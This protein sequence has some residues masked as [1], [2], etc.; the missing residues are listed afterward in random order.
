MENNLMK[1]LSLE[2]FGQPLT[3][4]QIEIPQLAH[5]EVLIQVEATPINPSDLLFMAGHYSNSGFKPPCVP[6][7][8]GSGLVV[9]SGG[10]EEADSLLNKR[11]AFIFCKG[12]Y[13]QYTVT[14]S[15]NCLLINDDVTYNQAA[16]SFVNPLTV[17]GMLEVVKEARV[18]TVVHSAAASA[19]GRMMVRYFKNN[20]VEV[21]NIVRRQEQVDI[22]KKEGAT[23]ILNQNDQDFHSQLKKLT[24]ELNATIFFDAIAGSFT[25]QVL[26]QMPNKSTAYVYGILSGERN[27]VTEAELASR[28]QSVK[29]FLLS[30]WLQSITPELK[31]QSMEKLQKLI[32]TDLK[33]EISKEYSLQDGQ[34]AIEYYSKN[35]TQGKVLIKPQLQ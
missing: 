23:I 8:E 21:I 16:S 7:F 10:G 27:S 18:K 35:M 11:V 33:S 20:G 13:A 25:G 15:Q 32:K 12:A 3:F 2:N 31:R 14:N 34:Q 17:V 5:G 19:L 4:K 6:G 26:S 29:G 30:N 28:E 1:S 9:K 24:T 22:L